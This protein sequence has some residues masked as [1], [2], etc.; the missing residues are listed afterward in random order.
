MTRPMVMP[1]I[2]TSGQARWATIKTPAPAERAAPTAHA[3]GRLR[4]PSLRLGHC[5][6]IEA[7]ESFPKRPN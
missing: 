6:P 3:G 4:C 5:R 7:S 1:S 2:L